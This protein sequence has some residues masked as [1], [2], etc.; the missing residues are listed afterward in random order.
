MSS[1][2]ILLIIIISGVV[3]VNG[4]T[5]APNAIA[6]AVA[7]KAV[8]YR[9]AVTLAAAFNLLGLFVMSLVNSS[10]ADTITSMVDFGDVDAK[11]SLAALLSSM[12]AIVIFS[13]VAWYFGIPTSES[14]AL[15]A[16]LSGSAIAVSSFSSVNVL[17]WQKTLLGLGMSLVFSFCFGFTFTKVLGGKLQNLTSKLLDKLQIVSAGGMAFMHGAQDGQ[18]FVAV[19]VIADLLSKNQ[20]TNGVVIIR[21][22]LLVLVFCAMLMALGTS[23]GGK[24]IIET[25]GTKMVRLEKHQS[26]C[27]DLASGLTLLVASLTGIPMSTTHT[28]TTAIIGA[29][30]CGCNQQKSLADF[31]IIGEMML[32][33]CI[34]FPVCG[35]LGFFITKA[36]LFF[37]T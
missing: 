5:D 36:L 22:H 19:F 35:A 4:W 18:K 37:Y 1:L 30:L 11:T 21:E 14:H 7:T 31:K 26:V 12:V 13:V 34:T 33:W 25:V 6:G 15:I 9:K 2:Q 10:V 8:T 24:R 29:G 28:K 20:Y 27:A 17:A 16:S 23:V 3:F 32:A